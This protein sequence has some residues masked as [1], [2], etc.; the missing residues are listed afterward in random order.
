MKL[1][2]G[3]V[4]GG[5]IVGAAAV[6]LAAAAKKES[7]GG[8]FSVA[9]KVPAAVA[10]TDEVLNALEQDFGWPLESVATRYITS[11]PTGTVFTVFFL[12]SANT[13]DMPK[14]GTRGKTSTGVPYQVASVTRAPVQT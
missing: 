13:P 3:L 1:L 8:T 5:G 6:A 2:L 10:N 14:V 9:L 4:I 7:K 12:P 11:T